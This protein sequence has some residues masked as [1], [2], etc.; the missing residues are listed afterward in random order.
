MKGEGGR[1]G[2]VVDIAPK[3]PNT[4]AFFQGVFFGK[5][6]RLSKVN[7]DPFFSRGPASYPE[8]SG[9]WVQGVD[10]EP[11]GVDGF[12]ASR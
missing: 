4:N 8:K 12:Y 2:E 11:T 3:A 9:Y 6:D 7:T 5:T 10:G 1:G